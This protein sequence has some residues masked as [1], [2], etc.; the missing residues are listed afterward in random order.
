MPGLSDIALSSRTVTVGTVAVPVYGVSAQGISVLIERFPEVRDLFNGKDV[1]VSA[2]S[3]FT[4]VPTAIAAI[5]AAGIGA[6][7]DKD[8]EA[9]AA[10][11]SLEAQMDFLEAIIEL[12]MPKGIGPFVDR[13]RSMLEGAG[14]NAG[15]LMSN[16]GTN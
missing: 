8:Q 2:D 3:L 5:I 1:D 4:L 10:T 11:L 9:I 15:N 7:G 13:L 14:L 12:T 16:P 6:P